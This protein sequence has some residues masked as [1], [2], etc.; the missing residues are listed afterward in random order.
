M[1]KSNPDCDWCEED[2]AD[3]QADMNGPTGTR[4]FCWGCYKKLFAV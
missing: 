4:W 3:K 2:E 1:S